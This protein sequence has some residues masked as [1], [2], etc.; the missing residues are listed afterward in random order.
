MIQLSAGEI[1]FYILVFDAADYL[2]PISS[3]GNDS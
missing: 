2:K 3:I 1:T